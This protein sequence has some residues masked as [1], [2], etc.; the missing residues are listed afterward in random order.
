MEIR[1]KEDKDREDLQRVILKKLLKVPNEQEPFLTYLRQ[2]IEFLF[3]FLKNIV[4]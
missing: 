4:K 1:V 3:S 2:K